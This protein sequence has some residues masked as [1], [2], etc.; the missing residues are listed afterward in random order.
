VVS[1]GSQ[2]PAQHNTHHKHNP[3]TREPTNQP[4]KNNTQK[5]KRHAITG[6]GRLELVLHTH[7]H[8]H[9]HTHR[10]ATT[11]TTKEKKTQTTQQKKQT[12]ALRVGTVLNIPTSGGRLE[13]VLHGGELPDQLR[14][15]VLSVQF[16][17]VCVCVNVMCGCYGG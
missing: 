9:T 16:C 7:T 12:R 4:T 6:G 1:W 3:H 8:T 15:Q 17:C 2:E 10:K 13:L 14:R 11:N 5:A